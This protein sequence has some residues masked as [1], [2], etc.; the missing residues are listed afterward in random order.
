LGEHGGGGGEGVDTG[1]CDGLRGWF[2]D[3]YLR[4]ID[5]S[6]WLE[7]PGRFLGCGGKRYREKKDEKGQKEAL[8]CKRRYGKG[9]ALGSR[10][11]SPHPKYARFID[12]LSGT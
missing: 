9:G 10:G 3:S 11:R 6:S 4:G 5:R 2:A 7:Y 8:G 1:R 12:A